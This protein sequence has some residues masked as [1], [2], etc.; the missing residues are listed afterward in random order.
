MKNYCKP[1]SGQAII[2]EKEF[3][4]Q[5]THKQFSQNICDLARY[6]GWEVYRTWNSRH[7]PAGYPDLTMVRENA[8]GTASLLFAEL[9]SEKGKVTKTQ[10]QWLSILGK[11]TGKCEVYIWRPSDWENI[12]IILS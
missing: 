6:L 5:I 11:V 1:S 7:S 12:I 8:D 3:R 9:K 2:T 10:Q 4:T